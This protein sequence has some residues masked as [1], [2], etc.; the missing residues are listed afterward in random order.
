MIELHDLVC[1][2]S[3]I[4]GTFAFKI[5]GGELWAGG[6]RNFIAYFFLQGDISGSKKK[7]PLWIH[8]VMAFAL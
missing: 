5:K 4:N 3:N 7:Y 2:S 6:Y 8:L 1:L